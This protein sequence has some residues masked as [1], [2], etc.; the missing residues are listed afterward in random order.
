MNLENIGVVRKLWHTP[1]L[2]G[3]RIALLI[4][5]I[6]ELKSVCVP[7]SVETCANSAVS[8]IIGKSIWLTLLTI[9]P[10]KMS[11]LFNPVQDMTNS[12][13]NI[14][15]CGSSFS[16]HLTKNCIMDRNVSILIKLSWIMH[17]KRFNFGTFNKQNVL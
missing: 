16:K 10:I 9:I 7:Y 14:S 5:W 2:D 13:F 11:S 6:V 12:K 15:I 1:T 4:L 3:T 8:G 17:H